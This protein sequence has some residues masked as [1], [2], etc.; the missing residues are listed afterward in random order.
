[1]SSLPMLPPDTPDPK[2][3]RL[4]EKLVARW[5]LFIGSVAAGL[6]LLDA[7]FKHRITNADI[8]TMTR[9]PGGVE[10]QR[11]QD[12]RTAGR[13]TAWSQLAVDEICDRIAS[14][15][16]VVASIVAV[17]GGQDG[18]F[19]QLVNRDPEIK[20]QFLE[21]Q[22]SG[23]IALGEQNLSIADDTANDTLE[24]LKGPIPNMA[25]V[26]R[27]KLRIDT[28]NRRMGQYNTKLFGEKQD[29]VNVQVN[30]NNHAETLEA[31]RQRDK[32]R[33]PVMTPKK[34]A[35]AVDAVFS[36]KPAE[37]EEPK[38]DAWDTQWREEK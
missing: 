19:Y 13:R 21:A 24:T 37:S 1:M 8:E 6:G 29:N 17:R 18:T 16:E 28:R 27:A 22:A 10:A 26:T 32:T 9:L 3:S 14:G 33:G 35:E 38:D 4:Q 36:E 20:K 34:L 2:H 7:K 30:V 23:M 12:A 31:A 5:D 25:A 15:E 11:W